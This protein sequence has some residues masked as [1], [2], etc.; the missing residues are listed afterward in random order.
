[1]GWMEGKLKRHLKGEGQRRKQVVRYKPHN[2]GGRRMMIM[3]QRLGSE[4][5][6]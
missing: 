2:I 1:M 5:L 4:N 3:M 6:R